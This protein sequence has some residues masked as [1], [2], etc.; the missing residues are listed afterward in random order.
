MVDGITLIGW[1]HEY[2]EDSVDRK[3]TPNVTGLCGYQKCWGEILVAKCDEF[4]DVRG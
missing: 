4:G 1:G 2:V 3:T